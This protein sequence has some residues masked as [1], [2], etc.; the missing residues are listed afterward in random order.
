MT[1]KDAPPPKHFDPAILEKVVR[2]AQAQGA[3]LG[4]VDRE[5]GLNKTY[6]YKVGGCF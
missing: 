5:V 1:F 3:Q 4:V 6:L 2:E